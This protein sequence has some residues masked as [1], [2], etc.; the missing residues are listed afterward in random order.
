M[1]KF[2]RICLEMRGIDTRGSHFRVLNR[3]FACLF[4][5]I[6]EHCGKEHLLVLLMISLREVSPEKLK[7]TLRIG[8]CK[9]IRVLNKIIRDENAIVLHM[10]SVYFRYWDRQYLDAGA[11]LYKF[12]HVWKKTRYRCGDYNAVTAITIDYYHIYA[13]YYVCKQMELA[14]TMAM[15]LFM[16]TASY[17]EMHT[18]P[19]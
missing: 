6:S 19:H 18:S 17:L 14:R 9:S 16:R 13:V 11:F 15:Y 8:Y 12:Q 7:N 2:W 10:W 4:K 1:I 5:T 3:L